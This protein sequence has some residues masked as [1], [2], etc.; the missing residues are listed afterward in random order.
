M[1]PRKRKGRPRR[2]FT[3]LWPR[4]SKLV[5]TT[6]ASRAA[7][8]LSQLDDVHQ[9]PPRAGRPAVVTALDLIRGEALALLDECR[10]V[11]QPPPIPLVE[12]FRR[13]LP[14]P[15][16]SVSEFS[17]AAE[18]EEIAPGRRRWAQTPDQIAA[19][20]NMRGRDT[21]IGYR[22][23]PAYRRSAL[24]RALERRLSAGT[25]IAEQRREWL[26]GA[27]T[28]IGPAV[29]LALEYAAWLRVWRR[30]Q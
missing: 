14:A 7:L 10:A 3:S 18:L 1:T 30:P 15:K 9:E 21:V 6:I 12:L 17:K 24:T 27:L 16:E 13:L 20:L 22:R 8:L 2:I 25:D 5:A 29:P 28:S 23:D 26:I 11:G 19:Q 4:V